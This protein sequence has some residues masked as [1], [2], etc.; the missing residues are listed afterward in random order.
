MICRNCGSH[1]PDNQFACDN[2]GTLTKEVR[3]IPKSAV[4]TALPMRWFK[5]LIYFV[6]F[7]TAALYIYEGVNVLLGGQ[8]AVPAIEAREAFPGLAKIDIF[9]A[10]G[11]IFLAGFAIFARFGL[12]AY[13]SV[14]LGSLNIV[15]AL[16]MALVMF[17][18]I[19]VLMVTNG[20][21]LDTVT[22]FHIPFDLV[23]IAVNSA[24]FKK[25]EKLFVN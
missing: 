15:Y 17:Y 9:Y 13:R 7:A 10:I 11:S 18:V 20:E 8:Y 12:A 14:G 16:N 24:Y 21:A 25:R 1:V 19:A 2:C 23:M 3:D 4:Q 6:L 22:L 5:F